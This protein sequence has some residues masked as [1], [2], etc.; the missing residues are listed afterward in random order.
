MELVDEQIGRVLEALHRTGRLDDT[1]IIFL[2]D[3]GANSGVASHDAGNSEEQIARD[4]DNSLEHRG[5]PG[6]F[7]SM[8][9]AWAEVS[10]SPLSHF[11]ATTFEGGIQTP[12]IVAGGPVRLRGVI[13][14]QLLHVTDPYPTVLDLTGV[15]RPGT[16]CREEPPA[17]EGRSL[18][19]LLTGRDDSPVRDE[20]DA[21][22]FEMQE[23]RSVLRGRWKA[24]LAMPPWG[25]GETWRLFDL[26]ADP[27]EL[28]DLAAEHPQLLAEMTSQWDEYAE[29]VGYIRAD[30]HKVID[31]VGPDR[32]YRFMPIDVD[33]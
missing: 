11:K 7:V 2:S 32:F 1:V 14:D 19:P 27:R 29:R 23:S 31:D 24:V 6:S 4:F 3:N 13:T 21:L 33:Q 22:C 10:D 8:G 17:L 25:D 5:R 20:D 28:D 15:E 18:A 12:L 16:W 26:Q 30:G 9:G